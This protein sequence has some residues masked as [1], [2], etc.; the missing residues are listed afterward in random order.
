[1]TITGLNQR[2]IVLNGTGVWLGHDNDIASSST[3][4]TSYVWVF[5]VP[6]SDQMIYVTDVATKYIYSETGWVVPDYDIPLQISLDIFAE[7]TYTGTLGTL[8]QDI[9]EALVTAF[10]DRFGIGVS[11]YRSE[12]IDVVQEVD[13]VDHCRLLTPES[14]IFFNFDID[15]F[16]Q[17]QLLEYAPEYVYFTEDDIAIRIF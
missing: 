3:D 17:Q 8:T 5:T 11:I 1:P 2:Y 10:T 16:T 7:S 12:I 14:S 6:K 9:R 15:D 4:G 13:G